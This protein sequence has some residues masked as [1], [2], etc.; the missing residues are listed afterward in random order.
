M[1]K[2][3]VLQE[4]IFLDVRVLINRLSNYLKQKL[5]ELQGVIN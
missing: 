5:I 2:G 1:T 4:D 3:P